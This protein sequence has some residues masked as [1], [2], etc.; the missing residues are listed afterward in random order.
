MHLYISIIY[1]M[2]FTLYSVIPFILFPSIPY[3]HVLLSLPSLCSHHSVPII[4]TMVMS[5]LKRQ[6]ELGQL[7]VQIEKSQNIAVMK[8]QAEKREAKALDEATANM[9]E[10][11]ARGFKV[12]IYIYHIH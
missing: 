8:R 4:A 12:C 5:L 3:L 11:L 9:V 7:M 2:T 10:V 1:I 6:E